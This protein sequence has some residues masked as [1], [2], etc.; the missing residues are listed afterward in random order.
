MEEGCLS[1]PDIR[2]EIKRPETIKIQY[3]D[4]DGE[5]YTETF[6]NLAARVILHEIDHL[7]GKFFT[8]Y[9]QPAKR[10]LIQKRLQEIAKTGKP[11]TGIIV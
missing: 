5:S 6:T 11:S 1:I 4:L 9:L 7:N 8:D 10:L 2:A 3:Q